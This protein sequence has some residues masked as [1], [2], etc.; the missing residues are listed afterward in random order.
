MLGG[1]IALGVSQVV[2]KV[3]GGFS[4]RKNFVENYGAIL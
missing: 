1:N 2:G 3:E 4:A